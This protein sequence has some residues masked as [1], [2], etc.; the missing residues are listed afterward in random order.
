MQERTARLRKQW[1]ATYDP[2]V[3]NKHAQAHGLMG[4]VAPMCIGDP[5]VAHPKTDPRLLGRNLVCTT[6]KSGK[7]GEGTTF[8]QVQP[9]CVGDPYLGADERAQKD[10]QR[11]RDALRDKAPFKPA[12]QTIV[13]R[14]DKFLLDMDSDTPAAEVA[15]RK[16]A[17]RE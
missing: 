2:G 16:Q 9:N 12:G 3:S 4:Q 1:E 15:A 17:A 7:V 8:S 10:R 14:R 5:Y 13:G 6:S 11:Q